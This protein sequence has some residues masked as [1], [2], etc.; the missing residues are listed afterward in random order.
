MASV[1]LESIRDFMT[2]R[3]Y[4]K[5]TIDTYQYWIKFYILY[6]AKKHPAKLAESEVEQFLSYLSAKSDAKRT[7]T[8]FVSENL[9]PLPLWII[10]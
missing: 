7:D 6:H 8:Y 1:F 10:A 9:A 5:R 4:A 2:T 3:R